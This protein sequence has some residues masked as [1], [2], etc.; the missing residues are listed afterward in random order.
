MFKQ[1]VFIRLSTPEIVDKLYRLG[2]R[3]GTNFWYSK[4][5]TLLI[6]ESDKYYC[7]DDERGNAE[8]LIKRG[9]IDCQNNEELFLA[10]AALRNDSDKHQWFICKLDYL[11]C[12][13][14]ETINK[15]DWQLNIK[16]NRLTYSLKHLWRKA[17]VKELIKHFTK[18]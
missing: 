9:Y 11:S 18:K 8:E 16:Y 13:N 12:H 5:S 14:L 17:S 15:G 2:N 7:L 3:Q 4:N 10:I 1:N 6:A